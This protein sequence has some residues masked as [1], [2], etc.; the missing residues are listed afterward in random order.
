MGRRPSSVLPDSMKTCLLPIVALALLATGCE[1]TTNAPSSSSGAVP[2]D[3]SRPA[4][5]RP[6]LDA[7]A[8]GGDCAAPSG[9]GVD[10]S[11]D[12]TSDEVWRA[13]DGPHRIDSRVRVLADVTVEACARVV[14]G[15]AGALQ[16]GS[17]DKNGK[18]I[19]KGTRTAD[20]LSPVLFGAAD[21]AKSWGAIV[22]DTKGFVDLSYTVIADGDAPAM[23]QS[24]G[25]ALRVHGASSPS[26]GGTPVVSPAVRA[27]WLLVDRSRGAGINLLHYAAFTEDSRGVAV[28]GS[29]SDPLRIEIGAVSTV[30]EEIVLDGNE[31]DEI[32]VDQTWQGTL[33]HTFKK[34]GFP[35]RV[36][37][38]IYLHPI[39]NGDPAVMTIEPGVTLRFATKSGP[40]GV[41][42]GT[43]K[44]RM[45]QIVARGT[46]AEPIVFTSPNAAPAPGDW[47]GLWFRYYPARGNAIE[48][49]VVEYAG[50]QSGASSHG[51]GPRENDASILIL[52]GR[53]DEA[54]VKRTT[55]RRGAGKTGIVSGWV[56]N[57]DGPSFKADNVFEEMPACVVSRWQGENGCGP[58][59]DPQCL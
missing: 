26:N 58:S 50:A 56:S 14:F 44:E 30:P 49:A 9:A 45:G 59:S 52:G 34:R 17:T 35:Y 5:P 25:G 43:T 7:M 21:P 39:E 20:A 3:P 53:P 42:V 36:L 55:L 41:Y 19:A 8:R 18:L 6:D 29:K 23:Q 40:G 28:R 32:A 4:G 22:V 16:V 33:S 51:C 31:H 47:L 48:N 1:A 11:G 57:L 2:G 15:E 38:A 10:H 12:I 54:F 24:G 27:D 46:A 37:S 13:A